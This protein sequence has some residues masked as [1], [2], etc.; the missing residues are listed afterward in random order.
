MAYFIFVSLLFTYAQGQCLGAAF[1]GGGARGSYEAGVLSVITDPSKNVG[2]KYNVMT[3]ISIG[4]LTLNSIGGFPIGQEQEMSQFLNEMW[5][6]ITDNSDIFN[7]WRGG[8]IDGLLFQRG[9]Y[10]NA[11]GTEYFHKYSTIPKRNVTVGAANLD[12]GTFQN[13]DDSLSSAFFDACVSSGSMP[14]F[15]PPHDFVGYTWMDGG[16]ILN[17]DIPSAVERCLTVTDESQITIDVLFDS[18]PNI[19]SNATSFKT[20][21]VIERMNEIRKYDNSIW[22]LYNSMKAYPKVFFR[23][24][25]TPSQTLNTVLNFTKA[26]IHAN[27]EIGIQDA[28][29]VISD[30]SHSPRSIV[31]THYSKFKQVVFP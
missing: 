18:Q 30:P 31:Q 5:F 7:E 13:F 2:V 12:F 8:L 17:L 1:E 15:F 23:H 28:N 27:Y 6:N 22:Y 9:L 21:K 29:N 20:I 26:A 19:L 24:L 16:T 25:F 3:G 14:F 4:A 11:K 10:N